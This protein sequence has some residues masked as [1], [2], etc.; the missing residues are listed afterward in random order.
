[1]ESI[2]LE[3]LKRNLKKI[4]D[5]RVIQEVIPF[6]GEETDFMQC[7]IKKL[8][9]E[10]KSIFRSPVSTHKD[11]FYI[12]C[13]R[14]S[15]A[16][17]KSKGEPTKTRA[18][19]CNAYVSFKIIKD[20]S[21]T[22]AVVNK[23]LHH[24]GHDVCLKEEG[25][26][27]RIDAE[28][29]TFIEI[30]L[31]QG[32]SISETLLKCVEWAE[33]HGH[34]DKYNRR[35]YVTPE[36]I[37]LIKKTNIALSF[38]D[39]KDCI[40]VDKLVT[41]ELEENIR[42]YQPLS[43]VQPLII[44]VQTPWQ[45]DI[46]KEHPHT[47]V[48]MDATYKAMT[49]YGY[50]FYELLLTNSIG[51]AVPFAYFIISEESADILALCLEKLAEHNPGFLPRSIM[52]DRDLKELNAIRRVFPT[53]KV[54]LCWFHVL[55][56]VHRWMVRRDGGNMPVNQRN[57]VIQALVSM[58]SCLTEEEFN[59]MSAKKCEELDAC[60]GTSHVST[61]LKNHWISLGD[62][63]SNFGR[64]FLTMKYQFLKGRMNSR[65]D[66]LLRLLCGD[67]QKYYSYLDELT[68][69]GRI[70][71]ANTD[72]TTIA[73][74]SMIAKGLDAKVEMYENGVCLIPPDTRTQSHRVD[75][76][77]HKCD[78][79][80]FQCGC[81][82]KHL[83]F[84][85]NIAEKQGLIIQD[86]RAEVARKIVESES[87]LT[88]DENLTVYHFDGSVGIVSRKGTNFCTCTANSYGEVCV[89][90]LVHNFLY[91]TSRENESDNSHRFK[92]SEKK[93]VTLQDM[94]TDL[95]EWSKSEKFHEDNEVYSLVQRAHKLV[96]SQFSKL[97][98]KR[99]VTALHNYRKSVKKAKNAI[100]VTYTVKKKKKRG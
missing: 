96:F 29:L 52:I 20:G 2:W 47:M 76:V 13:E 68:E 38:P 41:S 14:S 65:I 57:T 88:D 67:V 26:K 9:E 89:C 16:S 49:S 54:L 34:V 64:F 31:D 100:T 62:L 1:M 98:R 44:V 53:A 21:F 97:S 87:Y 86:L 58:K 7:Y 51:R 78:C 25:V 46:L 80:R 71:G 18:Y 79:K 32:K 84:S 66:Q 36:D 33:R 50:A 56:A 19:S 35:Y 60:L 82:C 28:L 4:K 3:G 90:I 12:A 74:H 15:K 70:K 69:N 83:I 75:L 37:R 42:Y 59:S 95:H 61:Y 6:S 22:G 5:A 92:F 55:Q 40:S 73:A 8:E 43:E 30:W 11:Y 94:L 45:K 17:G 24:N 63:W 85:R 81:V 27:N 77:M 91:K 23:M 72:E 93:K 39:A 48:F 10:T 99:K